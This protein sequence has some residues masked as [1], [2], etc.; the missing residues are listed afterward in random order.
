MLRAP[1]CSMAIDPR[2]GRPRHGRRRQGPRQADHGRGARPLG[3]PAA[4]ASRA[5]G[6]RRIAAGSSNPIDAFILAG[7]EA[8]GL[9][10][11]PEADRP[12]L[13]RR[14][15]FDL[16][17]LP[18]SPEEVEAFLRDRSPD[19]YEKVVD[20]LLASP[21]YGERWA[22]HWLD[23]ARYADTDGFEF[24]QARPNAWRYRDWVVD[25]LNRDMPYDRFVRLQ[26]AGDEVA[27]DDPSAFIATGFNRCYPDMVDLN[28]QGLRRQN[29]LER[30]HRDDRPG[31]PRPDD[32]LRPVPRPQV[33]PDPPGGFLPAPGVLRRRRGS[34]T[35]IPL[36]T[37]GAAQGLRAGR[38]RLAGRGRDGPGGDPPHREAGARPAR[39]GPADGRAR[40]RRGRATTRRSPS[41]PRPRSRLVYEP[42]QPRRPDPARATGPGCSTR[43]RPRRRQTLL[44]RARPR[45]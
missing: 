32:R 26:L 7:L 37:P 27:P 36:A 1:L 2:P 23:L 12:T 9:T 28:D 39:P 42:A 22:Q 25:A 38:R 35:T 17:G 10:P 16:T 29:A 20:R 34:A 41:G 45:R 33:R 30:H 13:L 21:Q 18:P 31:L 11:A 19:A 14:L 5:A 43:P 24:D 15:S 4:E 3:V 6:R 44:A 40:R 8:N